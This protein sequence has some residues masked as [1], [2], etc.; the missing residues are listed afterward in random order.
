MS[1]KL[2]YIRNNYE[3]ITPSVDYNC[4]LKRWDT[5]L[6]ETT[7]Q[8]SLKVPKVFKLTTQKH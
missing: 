3:Q 1:D 4:W 8:N 7:N 5:Q 6:D 2:M